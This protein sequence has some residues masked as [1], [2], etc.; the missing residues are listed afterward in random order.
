MVEEAFA[1][2]SLPVVERLFLGEQ[3]VSEHDVQN[4][5]ADCLPLY[6]T[7]ATLQHAGTSKESIQEG[8]IMLL[9][10]K[11][12]ITKNDVMCGPRGTET[13]SRWVQA[14][15][16]DR[17][18]IGGVIDMDSPGGESHA[19]FQMV[20]ALQNT[21]KPWVAITRY[22]SATSA[23]QG[24]AAACNEIHS[25]DDNDKFGSIGTMMTFL[26]M[27]KAMSEKLKTK[28]EPIYASKSTEKNGAYMAALKGD[29][30]PLRAQLL[31]PLN[32][33]FIAMMQS[34]RNITDDKKVFAG[35]TYYAEEAK[36]VGLI[37][38]TGSSLEQAVA[39]VEELHKKKNGGA[40]ISLH[41]GNNPSNTTNNTNMDLFKFKSKT[42][43]VKALESLVNANGDLTA[44]MAT[45]A[46]AEL[47]AMNAGVI[48]VPKTKDI[49]NV[50]ALNKHVAAL[51]GRATAAEARVKEL[52]T[53]NTALKAK[54]KGEEPVKEP[55]A[56]AD[57]KVANPGD[58]NLDELQHN[59]DAD[60][61]LG[62]PS[63][64]KK[65]TEKA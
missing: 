14:A 60:A 49:P 37:D 38:V 12:A 29:Y 6:A 36:S 39:R 9:P 5:V 8:S 18:V 56:S 25:E 30:A 1:R 46:Q 33:R 43:S 55:S 63:E 44:E 13:M 17:R 57:P 58:V 42:P 31:D 32:E 65:Q 59:K 50:E 41:I 21:Q 4:A 28:V 51:T 62:D 7:S 27:Y 15:E 48:L 34:L 19:M 40:T 10:M 64:I 3:V 24:I 47:D 54:P 11:N 20:A 45:A 52:E 26:D 2:S 23:M 16:A 61:L 35:R 53:E 22:G